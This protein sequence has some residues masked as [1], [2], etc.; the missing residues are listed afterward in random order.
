MKKVKLF[1]LY[2]VVLYSLFYVYR[3]QMP[4]AAQI[5]MEYFGYVNSSKCHVD[6]FEAF[7]DSA[8]MCNQNGTYYCCLSY[9]A[10]FF[11]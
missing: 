4:S 9:N 10:E 3:A 7:P 5:S 6:C 8:V 11:P 1:I 2:S